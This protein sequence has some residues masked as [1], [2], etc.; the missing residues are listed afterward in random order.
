MTA[1]VSLPTSKVV[2]IQQYEWLYTTSREK[3]SHC[4]RNSLLWESQPKNKAVLDLTHYISAQNRSVYL[5][6][7]I[8]CES[9]VPGLSP[10]I[11][12]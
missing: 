3:T 9:P 1:L 4:R 8:S 2:S 10:A 6:D 5:S 11:L 12:F 7:I